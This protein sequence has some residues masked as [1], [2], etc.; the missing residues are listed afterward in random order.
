M[1]TEYRGG[2]CMYREREI[3]RAQEREKERVR[4]RERETAREREIV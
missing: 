3:A 1:P 2:D 4:A